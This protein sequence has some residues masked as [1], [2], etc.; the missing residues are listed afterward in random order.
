MNPKIDFLRADCLEVMPFFPDN[1]FNL[2]IVD[3]PYGIGISKNPF[4]Q[5]HKIKKW[6]SEPPGPAYFEELFRISKNQIIFGGNYFDLPATQ[7]F[8]IWDKK[9]P[10]DFSSAMCEFIWT[11][12]QRPA[13]IYRRHVVNSE[14]PKIHPTEKPVQIYRW[15]L[16]KFAEPGDRVLD[17]HCGSG[18]IAVACHYFG[19]DLF[20]IE[21]DPDYL[22]GAIERFDRETRQIALAF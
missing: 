13:K 3:P 4:R 6:D 11:S 15:L 16:S 21:K 9:Q 22:N 7:G 1:Y 8:I 10:E 20:A 19:V 12:F 2:A 17:T 14:T 5:K 18:S